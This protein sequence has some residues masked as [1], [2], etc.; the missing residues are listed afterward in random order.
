MLMYFLVLYLKKYV[1]SPEV[2]DDYFLKLMYI[3]FFQILGFMQLRFLYFQVQK[4]FPPLNGIVIFQE[5]IDLK[6]D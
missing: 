3:I 1:E 5:K 6:I 2:N 4:T